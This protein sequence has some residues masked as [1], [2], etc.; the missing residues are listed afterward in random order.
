MKNILLIEDNEDIHKLVKLAL[1]E[2]TIICVCSLNDVSLVGE[3]YLLA[4][5]DVELPD[6][7]SLEFIAEGKL[8][9]NKPKIFLT[10]DHTIATQAIA[11]E[12]G[13][14]D[15]ITKPFKALDLNM[16]V[17]AKIRQHT[18]IT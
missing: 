18:C 15:F 3:D 12:L 6:G 7:N 10:A 14:E 11:Y 1:K 2:Y 9:I 4:I 5:I 17:K 16:R 13:A 8:T